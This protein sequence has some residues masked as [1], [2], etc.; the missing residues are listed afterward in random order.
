LAIIL[1]K[2][3]LKPK[4]FILSRPLFTLAELTA[5]QA[6]RGR[7]KAET[8]R[9]LIKH[10]INAGRIAVVSQDGRSKLGRGRGLYATVPY[11]TSSEALSLDP[12]LV[13]SKL[14][15]DAV[16][17]YHSSLQFHGRAHSVSS[18]LTILTSKVVKAFTWKGVEFTGVRPPAALKRKH[19]EQAGVTTVDH[20]GLP[21]RVTALERTL[22]DVLDRPDLGG[23]WEEVFR[24][25]DSIEFLDLD[26]VLQYVAQLGNSTTAA[27]V[28][29]YLVTNRERLHVTDGHLKKL[30]PLLPKRPVYMDQKIVNPSTLVPECRLRVPDR[31]LKKTWEEPR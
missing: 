8:V 18:R 23:G 21:I 13:A 30:R 31:V 14:A 4:D 27:K 26:Q 17:A 28:A 16:V 1:N 2:N 11:G 9:T 10:Y 22:V 25:L 24:S 20:Q 19:K 6:H 12:Y 15:D 29:Y 7:P 5:F 3:G